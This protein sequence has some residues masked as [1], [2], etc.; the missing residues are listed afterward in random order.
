MDSCKQILEMDAE[1]IDLD[2]FGL[3]SIGEV[4]ELGSVKVIELC[5]RGKSIVVNRNNREK[6]ISLL[7]WN[8][9][10]A[11]MDEQVKQFA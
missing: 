9:C 5:R 7:I 1:F 10:V 2:A 6:Y 4:E 11:S 8:C 3:T